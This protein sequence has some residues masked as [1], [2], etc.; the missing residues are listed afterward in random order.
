MVY[1]RP[2]SSLTQFARSCAAY[3]KGYQRFHK[4]LFHDEIAL[5]AKYFVSFKQSHAM[6]APDPRETARLFTAGL[7]HIRRERFHVAS[8][9]PARK[10]VE[11]AV[12]R[13]IDN[14]IETVLPA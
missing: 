8:E 6:R 12:Q 7:V 13:Y 11:R 1:M 2:T 9:M 5:L 10:D 14:F 4:A 3:V